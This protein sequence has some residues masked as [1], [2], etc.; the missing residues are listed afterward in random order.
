MVKLVQG[1]V[2]RNVPGLERIESTFRF[3]LGELSWQ[4]DNRADTGD[5]NNTSCFI[6]RLGKMCMRHPELIL[7]SI[8][9]VPYIGSP[10]Y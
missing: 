9:T 10:F 8:K 5:Y 2:M 3:L 4:A 6:G 7:V 1:L